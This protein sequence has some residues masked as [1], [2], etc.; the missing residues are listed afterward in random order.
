MQTA[1]AGVSTLLASSIFHVDYHYSNHIFSLDM[2]SKSI[3]TKSLDF[4]FILEFK[5]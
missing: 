2:W 5:I 4:Y 3:V 1:L